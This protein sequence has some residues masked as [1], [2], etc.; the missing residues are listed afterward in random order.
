MEKWGTPIP[1]TERG[2]QKSL[3]PALETIGT[4]RP[5]SSARWL[6]QGQGLPLGLHSGPRAGGPG[7]TG[8]PPHTQ[9]MEPACPFVDTGWPRIG[10]C[11]DVLTSGVM[12]VS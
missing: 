9:Y 4:L 6:V 12:N 8:D 3:L 2:P 7:N 10:G 11:I 5:T 1:T